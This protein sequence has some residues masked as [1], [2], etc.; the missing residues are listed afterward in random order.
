[1]GSMCRLHSVYS[2]LATQFLGE[3]F[4]KKN[5][6]GIVLVIIGSILAVVF[7]PRTGG[8]SINIQYLLAQWSRLSFTL[9]FVS[10]SGVAVLDFIGI[11]YYERLNELDESVDAKQIKHGKMFLL[12]SY[13]FMSGYFGANAFLF[14]KAFAEFLGASFKSLEDATAALVSWYVT[15]WHQTS[16]DMLEK[17][18]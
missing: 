6:L 7:G 3:P 18:C 1:M 12:L 11:K 14:I 15:F 17:M 10:L 2:L 9:F 13:G 16:V 8:E 5:Y 4:K